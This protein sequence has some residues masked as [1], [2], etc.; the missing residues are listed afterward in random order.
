[1]SV[2]EQD[3]ARGI[4]GISVAAELVGMDQ[5][6]LRL[7]EQRD[8]LTPA[9]TSGGTRRYSADDLHRLR[10]IRELLAAGLN[11]AGVAMVLHLQDDNDELR[12]EMD[13]AGLSRR[14]PTDRSAAGTP[15]TGRRPRRGA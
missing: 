9:R 3:P 1:V 5:Q 7:Y 15:R 14:A 4:Y 13:R 2:P 11:L 8:L 12:G 6:R 10:R